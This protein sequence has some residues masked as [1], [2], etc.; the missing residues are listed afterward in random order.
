[1]ANVLEGEA[2]AISDDPQIQRGAYLARTLGHCGMCHS[3]RNILGVEQLAQ[4]FAGAENVAPDISRSG[5]SVWTEEDFMG[6]LQLGMTAN[7]DFVGGE[8]GV[9]IKHNTSQLTEEDQQ[10]YTAFFLRDTE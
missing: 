2:P 10:A 5:L 3:P 1:M 8:M 9:V 4:E 7:F 6:L